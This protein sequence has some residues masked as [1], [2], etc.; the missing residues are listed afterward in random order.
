MRPAPPRRALG[1]GQVLRS[2]SCHALV[3]WLPRARYDELRRLAVAAEIEPRLGRAFPASRGAR[4]LPRLPPA[5]GAG[6]LFE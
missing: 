1:G 6:T 4:R 3:A 5:H 2:A